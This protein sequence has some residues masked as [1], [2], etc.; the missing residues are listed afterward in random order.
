M[1][2]EKGG[3]Q[4]KQ[5]CVQVCKK[6]KA[7]KNTMS[8]WQKA[9]VRGKGG[10]PKQRNKKACAR[11]MKT[12]RTQK[13]TNHQQHQSRERNQS[14]QVGRGRES[15]ENRTSRN[16]RGDDGDGMEEEEEEMGW[17]GMMT[18]TET[19]MVVW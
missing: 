12:V 16:E 19:G 17:G 15:G 11:Q 2:G 8:V 1:V 6:Q 7:G 18:E 9:S 10:V 14:N 13:P 5:K 4:E 3:R